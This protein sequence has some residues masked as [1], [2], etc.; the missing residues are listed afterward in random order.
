[1]ATNEKGVVDAI[2]AAIMREHP[3][4]WTFKVVG[5][6]LQMAGVPDLLVCIDGLLLGIEVKFQRPGES[7]AHAVGRATPQQLVQIHRLRRAGAVADVVTAPEQALALIR[8]RLER[9]EQ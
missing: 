3:E 9:R 4:N 5:S 2:R 6:P 8:A 1:V 7:L